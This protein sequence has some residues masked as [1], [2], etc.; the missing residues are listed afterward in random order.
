MNREDI[1][2]DILPCS[3]AAFFNVRESSALRRQVDAAADR[4]MKRFAS[5][6]SKNKT[7]VEGLLMLLKK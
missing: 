5:M 3:S 4:I 2:V 6:E 7:M 1:I